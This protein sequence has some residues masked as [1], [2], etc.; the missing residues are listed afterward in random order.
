MIDFEVLKASG[1]DAPAIA[2]LEALLFSDAWSEKSVEQTVGS[3]FSLALVAKKEG[4]PCAYLLASLLPPEGEL[5]RIGVHP[6]Y[7]RRGIGLLLMEAFFAEAEKLGCE[8]LF[9]EVRAKNEPAIGLYRRMGFSH[10]GLRKGYYHD[11]EDDA[12]LM[13]CEK[14]TKE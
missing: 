10:N 4:E 7:R 3:M 14:S 13:V 5:Y 2:E 8:T 9:L 6:A 11:P 12:L 1:E